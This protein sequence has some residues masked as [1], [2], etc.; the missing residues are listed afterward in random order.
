MIPSHG[1]RL[2]IYGRV[3]EGRTN[4]VCT[5]R[6]IPQRPFS[7]SLTKSYEKITK[8]QLGHFT[9]VQLIA[10]KGNSR[11]Q[12]S[13][14]RFQIEPKTL[15]WTSVGFDQDN[16]PVSGASGYEASTSQLS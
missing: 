4:G 8:N 6:A 15:P 1:N 9:G 12:I 7:E 3:G 2:F 11:F 13:N 14:F 16:A 10:G 5:R